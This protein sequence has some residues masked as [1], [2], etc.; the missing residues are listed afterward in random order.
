MTSEFILLFTLT[1][2][3]YENSEFLDELDQMQ[4]DGTSC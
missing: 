1:D 3:D 2:E 4:E